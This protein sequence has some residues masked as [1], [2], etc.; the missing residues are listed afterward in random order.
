[1]PWRDRLSVLEARGRHCGAPGASCDERGSIA[2]EPRG[3]VSEWLT[4][5]GQREK[6]RA[7]LWEP[8]AVAALNQSPDVAAA[9]PFVRVLAEMFGPN[10]ADSALVLPTTPL[11][12]MY[13]EPAR[14]LHRSHAAER[15]ASMRW[16]ASSSSTDGA[17]VDIRGER[18]ATSRVIAAVP[19][20]DLGRLFGPAPPPH[21]APFWL[22]RRAWSRC[23][24]SPS[25]SGTTAGDGRLVRR[26]A[27]TRDA[28]G[29]RQAARVRRRR[30]ASVARF[31][32]RD[33]A[34]R[35]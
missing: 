18:I 29:L 32:R 6:L 9:A 4:A 16:R 26:T 27:G 21:S 14:A 19:W 7:W 30:V 1:M 25:I 34:D 10:A 17:G 28:V 22:S 2:A 24:S 35:R 11:H 3:T 20:F 15:F 33:A 12:E 13:A 8:L 31:E 23:R 5:H